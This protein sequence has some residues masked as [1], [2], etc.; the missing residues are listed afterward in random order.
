MDATRGKTDATCPKCRE[1]H[2][3][4][5][6][7]VDKLLTNF[8]ANSLLELIEIYEA[9]ESE[10]DSK[11]SLRCESGLDENDAAARCLDC[12]SYLCQSCWT[13]HKK[14]VFTRTHKMASLSEIR[15]AGEKCLHKPHYCTEHDG[16]LLKLYC[17]TC[18]KAICGDCTYVEHRKHEYVFIKD[19]QDE[20]RKKLETLVSNLTQQ[21]NGLSA[22]LEFLCQLGLEQVA[23]VDSCKEQIAQAA[24]TMRQET[25]AEEAKALEAADAVLRSC[26]K[27][28]KAEEDSVSLSLAKVSSNLSF[29]QRLLK[30]GSD[31]E[32]A[33]AAAQAIKRS[34]HIC[35]LKRENAPAMEFP[36]V[37]CLAHQTCNINIRK[38]EV[39]VK[40]KG[41]KDVAFGLNTLH[42]V[43]S[44]TSRPTV[45]KLILHPNQGTPEAV[46]YTISPVDD[47]VGEWNIEFILRAGGSIELLLSVGA[48]VFH[49]TVQIG[50]SM[51]TG[52]RVCRGPTWKWKEQDG[53]GLGTVVPR[54]RMMIKNDWIS[55]EWDN[56]STYN[57]RWTA[58][59]DQVDVVIV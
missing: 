16:E 57:Y 52:T 23:N 13:M 30:S 9:G 20:L 48:S 3:L 41:T 44:V 46:K 5:G 34:E 10:K 36:L 29:I 21:E 7:R 50:S 27:V 53:H 8:P 12:N 37:E 39:N 14:L 38:V 31:A 6:G 26:Q 35:K 4:P 32:I 33:S 18:S 55:V 15:D 11:K 28:I 56:G 24:A 51:R 54:D 2:P 40:V 43:T 1:T 42:V 59:T 25:D 49:K 19:A 22:R 45:H 47:K 17:E 58:L